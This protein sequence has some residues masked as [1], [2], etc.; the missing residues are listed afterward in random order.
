[1]L[2][3]SILSL[4]YCAY[5]SCRYIDET[6][7]DISMQTND[8]NVKKGRRY[9]GRRLAVL[10]F[11]RTVLSMHHLSILSL[12]YCAYTSCRYIDETFTDISMLA[13]DVNVKKCCRYIGNKN[14]DCWRSVTQRNAPRIR[15]GVTCNFN[16]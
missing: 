12:F 10:G 5:M 16:Y 15:D 9:I 3:L 7:T 4:Y 1:M 11:C 2:H 13:N 14:S 8:V 6:F